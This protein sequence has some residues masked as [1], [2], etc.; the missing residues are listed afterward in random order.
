LIQ[1]TDCQLAAGDRW[2]LAL[3]GPEL[4]SGGTRD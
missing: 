3:L 1:L 4:A 2:P